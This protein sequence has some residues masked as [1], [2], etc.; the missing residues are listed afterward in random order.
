VEILL[1]LVAMALAAG[2]TFILPLIAWARTHRLERQLTELRGRLASLEEAVR[3]AGHASS[4]RAAA[5][6]APSSAAAVATAASGDR[7][8]AP[9]ETAAAFVTPNAPVVSPT[10]G[11]AYPRLPSGPLAQPAVAGDTGY[12][13]LPPLPKP[14]PGEAHASLEAAIGGR[15]LL[16]VGTI[17]LVLGVAFFLKYAFDNDWITESMRVVMGIVGGLVLAA[18][19]HRFAARGYRAYGQ[20]L[21]GGGL[22]VLYLSIYVAFGYYALIGQTPAFLLLV[23]VTVGAAW[24]ADRQNALGLALMAVGG[25]FATPFLV[26]SGT[27]AQVTLFSYDAL[28]VTGTLYLARRRDWPVLNL[29]SFL[30]TWITV[31]GWADE[32]YRADKWRITE[33]FL[34]LFCGLFLG[35]LIAQLR[36]H[37]WKSL[38]TLVLATGPFIY[39]ASSLAVLMGHGA[40][41]LVYLIAVTLVAVAWAT[42]MHATRARV[43]AWGAVMVPLL[44]WLGTHGSRHW[45]VANL[46]ATCGIFALH[47]LAQLDVVFRHE[48]RLSKLD[49]VLMHLNG[50]ALV[51]GIYLAIEN[52]AL[53]NA[54]WA[55]AAIAA[56]HAGLAWILRQVDRAAA[57]HALAV[58]IGAATIAVALRLDGPWLTAALAVEGGLV[59]WLGLTLATGWYRIA[60][61]G[62]LLSAILRYGSLSLP[63]KPAVFTLFGDEAF[64]MGATIAAVFLAVAWIYR[65]YDPSRLPEE[66]MGLIV[67]VLSACVL[68]VIA[69]SAENDNYWTL[70]G[71]TSP[72]A[73]FASSLALSGIWTASAAV[74]IA[75]GFWRDFAPLRY[76][77]IGLFGLTVLKVFLV[78]LSELGGIYRILGF[79]GVGVVLLV[80]SFLYQR[81]RKK[82]PQAGP[83]AQEAGPAA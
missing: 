51:A 52:V 70:R 37:G 65:R 24:L 56:V 53:A 14:A 71:L 74:F 23:L 11:D 62:L 49:A 58:G 27:D 82:T 25:G 46:V 55:A 22:A 30:A 8:S 67:P 31:A 64:A 2:V 61:A 26:G 69:L 41:P 44:G 39:H 10:L 3:L 48:R 21:T 38:V 75:L 36:R 33:F 12:A 28:L 35:I 43:V 80:V 60:G 20:I 45:L 66:R 1:G 77:A 73:R 32:F 34:T 42:R 13:A 83:P 16:W 78:D 63:V 40:A 29:V 50:Y 15:L 59:I 4:P 68:L 19:G 17:V 47:A 5:P 9:A 72:D 6:A 79:M 7:T 76:L 18:I 81:T 57:L 54:P